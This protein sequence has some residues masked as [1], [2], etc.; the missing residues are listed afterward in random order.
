MGTVARIGTPGLI[1]GNP[2]EFAFEWVKCTV[3]AIKPDGFEPP[4]VHRYCPGEE[5]LLQNRVDS[6][7]QHIQA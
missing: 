6:A 4:V 2:A 7:V 5:V 3:L 1:I